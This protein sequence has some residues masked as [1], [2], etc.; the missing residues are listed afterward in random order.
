[1]NEFI[2]RDTI[3]NDV[4]YKKN[5]YCERTVLTNEA[6]VETFFVNRMLC[7]L[8]YKDSNIKTKN[9]IETFLLSKGSKKVNYKPDYILLSNGKPVLIIDAKSIAENIDDWKEQCAHYCLIMNRGGCEVRYFL[10]TNGISTKLYKWDTD[11]PSLVLDFTD[12]F[13]GN[14]KYE[15][16]HNLIS[17]SSIK[18][19]NIISTEN[20]IKLKKINKEEAQKLFI[21]CHKLIW[22]QEKRSPNSAFIEFV[23]LIFVKLYNDKRIHDNYCTNE[24]GFI[25]VPKEENVFS[26]HWIE[27]RE[28]E[29]SNPINDIQFK[30]LMENLQD[31]VTKNHKKTI[32]YDGEK[33][34]LKPTTTKAVVKK[35]ENV[36]LFG[37]DEDLNGRLFETFLN[38]TMRGKDLGQFFTP[39]SIVLLGTLIADLEVSEKHIDRVL[40]GSCGSGG[41]LIEALTI[42][43]DIVRKNNS[44]S[45]EKKID[46]INKISNES[47]FGIDA[48]VEPNLAKIARINMYLHG[49][50]GSHIY[51]ADGLDK[52]ITI[53]KT[54]S[55]IVKAELNDMKTNILSNSFDVVLTNPPFS[56]WYELEDEVQKKIVKDYKLLVIDE[57]TNKA[58]NR[59]RTS[60]MFI[61]RYKDL[62]KIGGKL[63]S[64]IDETI[65]ASDD[66]SY[67]RDFIR[68]HFII[69]AVISLHG[70]AFSMSSARVK[71]ALVYL[72][73][74]KN[75]NEHQPACFMYSSIHLGVDDMPITTQANKI[76]EARKRAN[77]EIKDILQQFKKFQKGEKG[78]WY[79]EPNKLTKRLDVKSCINLQGR[80]ISTWEAKGYKI[81]SIGELCKEIDKNT[82][83]IKPKDFAEESF[84]IL[85][86]GYNGR[87]RAEETR[88]GKHINYSTM[89]VLKEGDLV[90]S[91][92]NAFNGAIGYITQEFEECLASGSYTVVRCD[93]KNISLYLWSILRTTEIKADLLTSAV[94]MGRQTIDWDNIKQVKLPLLSNDEINVVAKNILEAWDKEKQINQIYKNVQQTL[95]QSFSVES[96]E[97]KIRFLQTKPPK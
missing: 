82:Q 86:I 21:S 58:R 49:D 65:L 48:A 25:F 24:D 94:G 69:K 26:I 50:G 9:S 73:K 92:Y 37:I 30:R 61:E 53:E 5:I 56:M 93:D 90:F 87:C 40:D 62:L 32:F 75:Q 68:K 18:K 38:A 1:M 35:L 60:A 46:L 13:I 17:S 45:Q 83:I 70:D 51:C 64:V 8:G 76:T 74:K 66:Y 28:K 11:I 81:S 84:R 15:A 47:L 85:T 31:E 78:V 2:K 80:Y 41:F 88:L 42:M 54:E 43:R 20:L 16:L 34:E 55:P 89:I 14:A 52:H 77:E 33:I 36:D 96:E 6:S 23:K 10:L 91:E 7:D 12:F 27:S 22:N 39:R 72:Q 29:T 4:N 97:S 19:K 71:T 63:I 59:L 79:V 95:H 57:T 67:V 3:L 44:Y